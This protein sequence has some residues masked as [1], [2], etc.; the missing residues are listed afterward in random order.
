MSRIFPSSWSIAS[1]FVRLAFL[2]P[3]GVDLHAVDFVQL[4]FLR[5]RAGL[6]GLL[7]G[8]RL[9]LSCFSR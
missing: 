7:R 6:G 5:L 3:P 8:H 9:L 2:V 4:G 1:R